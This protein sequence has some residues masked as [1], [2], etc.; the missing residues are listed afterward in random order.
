MV[1]YTKLNR[2]NYKRSNGFNMEKLTVTRVYNDKITTKKY[3]IKD[4]ISIYTSEY[5]E[6]KM[7]SLDKSAQGIKVGDTIE[8]TIEKNG[9]FTNFKMPKSE[10]S[11][12]GNSPSPI[13]PQFEERLKRLEDAVFKGVEPANV[14]AEDEPVF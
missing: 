14:L 4:K 5:P 6:T 12:G 2:S 11:W 3:G 10:R 13:Q 9:Q 1:H 8:V 7:S